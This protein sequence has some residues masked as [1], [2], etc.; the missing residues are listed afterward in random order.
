[1]KEKNSRG[2]ETVRVVGKQSS[3]E[4]EV[5]KYYWNLYR[6]EETFCRK[7]D[8]LEKIGEVKKISEEES[9]QLEERITME[10]VSKT[11]KKY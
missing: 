8:I 9:C 6:Q 10:E 7:E 2:E 11:L 3:V 4:W 5:Y 1:M